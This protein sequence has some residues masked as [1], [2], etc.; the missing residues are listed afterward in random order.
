LP[1]LIT[2]AKILPVACYPSRDVAT[3]LSRSRSSPWARMILKVYKDRAH[4]STSSPGAEGVLCAM[5]CPLILTLD[6][7]MGPIENLKKKLG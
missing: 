5:I 4:F 2:V 7:C 1:L 3:Y 6:P